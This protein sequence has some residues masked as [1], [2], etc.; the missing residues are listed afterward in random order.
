MNIQFLRLSLTLVL[1]LLSYSWVLSVIWDTYVP[2]KHTLSVE[3][4]F[5]LHFD[6]KRQVLKSI[7]EEQSQLPKRILTKIKAGKLVQLADKKNNVYFYRFDNGQVQMLGPINLDDS[8]NDNQKYLT[9][10][11]FIGVIAILLF[12][13]RP[14]FLELKLLSQKALTFSETASWKSFSIRKSSPISPVVEVC[15]QMGERIE[16]LIKQYKGISRMIGHEIRTPLARTQFSL[17]TIDDAQHQEELLSIQEDIDE[18]AALTEEFLNIAKLEYTQAEL[19]LHL[20]EVKPMVAD[21]VAR[22]QRTTR[23]KIHLDINDDLQ[24]NVEDVSFQRMTQNLIGNALKHCNSLVNVTIKATDSHYLLEVC[25]D[26]KGF[27]EADKAIKTYYQE[28]ST[29]DGFGLGLAIIKMIAKWYQGKIDI[30][31]CQTLNGA[32]VCFTWPKV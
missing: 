13:F 5:Q 20:V 9:L 22:F 18:I 25:D 15:N 32:R 16:E 21:L 8:A 2:T 17:A 29:K 10:L 30:G 31:T 14:L 11:Y 24:V 1:A 4:V 26:G 27:I 7:P 3:Q 28:D 19:P 12:W 23:H 6:Q